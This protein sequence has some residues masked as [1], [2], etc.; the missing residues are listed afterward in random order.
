MP[1]TVLL[2][3]GVD[4]ER[5]YAMPTIRYGGA[6]F[7]FLHHL[8]QEKMSVEVEL[9]TSRDGF[10]WDRDPRRNKLIPVGHDTDWDKGMVYA[11]DRVIENGD[12]WWLYYSGHSDYHVADG[13]GWGSVGL[14]RFR[15]EGFVSVRADQSG[16]TS[17]L[18][19]RPFRWPGGDLVINSD[20]RGGSVAVRVTDIRRD[21]IGKFSYDDCSVFGGD[22]IRHRIEWKS[23]DM[24]TLKGQ[25]IRLE[26][27]FVHADLFAFLAADRL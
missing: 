3:D 26:F 5:F 9:V 12:E 14:L 7:G 18:V 23:A 11:A 15:K 1:T 13:G 19:T 27:R 24:R 25:L 10:R 16:R 8:Q 4:G 6:Y 17:F 22:S 20:A 2:P 21:P